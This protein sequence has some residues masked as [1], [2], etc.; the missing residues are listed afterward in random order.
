MPIDFFEREVTKT[1]DRFNETFGQLEVCD[2]KTRQAVI[3]SIISLA[4][5][6]KKIR[7][8]R[9]K[10]MIQKFMRTKTALNG[11]FDPIEHSI[12]E[13]RH[14]ANSNSRAKRQATHGSRICG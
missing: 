1:Q 9:D 2:I 6:A 4:R 7:V 11:V 14:H 12:N 3:L 13:R 5:L 10:K 8:S